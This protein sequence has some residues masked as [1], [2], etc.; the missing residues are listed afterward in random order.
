MDEI[1]KA[2]VLAYN[3]LKLV[4]K[5]GAFANVLLRE[6][7]KDKK[8]PVSLHPLVTDIVYGVLRRQNT[9]DW[10]ISNFSKIERLTL[11]ILILLRIGVYQILYHN[12]P[13][14]LIVNETVEIGKRVISRKGG[15]LINAVLRKISN[16]SNLRP[17]EKD[18]VYSHPIWLIEKW[19]RELGV[20][21]TGQLCER[22]NR[23]VPLS[24][25]VNI[26]KTSIEEVENSLSEEG[27]IV[28][29]GRF[30]KNCLIL[31]EGIVRPI[32]CLEEEGKVFIQSESSMVVAEKLELDSGLKVL[33]GCSGYGG[34]TIYAGE[35]MR[36]SGEIIAIDRVKNK[37]DIL[38][39]IASKHS[40]S[41]IKT[42]HSPLEE[43]TIDRV[44]YVDRVLLDVPCSG[45]GT[46]S[47]RPEIKWRLKPEDI[48]RLSSAQKRILDAG[49]RFLKTG[50]ILIYSA[51]TISRD[52]TYD[53]IKSFL[54]N[55]RG[56]DLIEEVQFFPHR[57][58]V[59][60]FYMAKLKKNV[61]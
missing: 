42:I 3:I 44:G 43:L 29:R 14:P 36:N 10:Y 15:N 2:K 9:I 48:S 1:I 5:K 35:L 39:R 34:K 23:P 41:I 33:D 13:A 17:S 4:D 19:E 53:I 31:R 12:T 55:N 28:E 38:K 46:L 58:D 11:E 16:S 21:E 37:L 7:L 49:S 45:L 47:R 26:L 54:E 52:E 57:D 8:F 40:V 24:F 59:E 20:D 60:G 32:S 30:S 50:G 56:F 18:L 22:N 27:I 61:A 51:C 6:R 25:R